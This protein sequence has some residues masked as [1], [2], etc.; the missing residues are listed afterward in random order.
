[1]K[2]YSNENGRYNLC[3]IIKV[4]NNKRNMNTY[5]VLNA[6]IHHDKDGWV[7]EFPKNDFIRKK[8]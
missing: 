1:M 5:K 7:E 3:K 2:I 4:P 8:L 6:D